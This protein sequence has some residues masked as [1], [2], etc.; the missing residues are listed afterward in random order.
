M[1]L[2][3]SKDI[4][5][6]IIL[7]YTKSGRHLCGLGVVLSRSVMSDSI[8]HVECS[9]PGSSV[10]RDSPGKSTGVG[11]QGIIWGANLQGIIPTQGL[12]PGFPH[13]RWIPY[14]LSTR[15]VPP[16]VSVNKG[17]CSHQTLGYCSHVQGSTLRR[18][19]MESKSDKEKYCMTSH[20][21]EI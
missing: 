1:P 9:L 4:A 18:Y 13:C 21:C 8:D 10:H 3:C 14:C 11:C 2:Y 20:I 5:F 12:N 16:S 17:C 7:H 6:S 15:E 19:R